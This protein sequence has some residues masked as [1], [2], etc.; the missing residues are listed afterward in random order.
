MQWMG[1]KSPFRLAAAIFTLPLILSL[2][3][4]LHIFDLPIFVDYTPGVL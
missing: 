2:N 1:K 3:F 4:I